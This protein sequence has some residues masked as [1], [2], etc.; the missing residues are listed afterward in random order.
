VKPS[1]VVFDR[2]GGGKQAADTLRDKGFQVRT[3]S[4]GEAPSDPDTLKR[5]RTRTERE[6]AKE[7]GTVYLNRR[8]EMYDLLSQLLDPARDREDSF[9]VKAIGTRPD[10]SLFNVKRV[11]FAIPRE[12][13]EIRRQLAPLP[14]TYDSEG[15]MVLPPKNK[16]DKNDKRTTI[17][18][19]L[20]RSPDDADALV[21]SAFG[22]YRKPTRMEITAIL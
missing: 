21:L 11:G 4:F 5:G 16:R 20:G 6:V 3:I 18:E 15:R 12:Y 19:M 22:T 13:A 2:G 14:R 9:G 17:T 8:V 1:N 10:G 7:E